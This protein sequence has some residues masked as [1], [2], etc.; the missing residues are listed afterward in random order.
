[1]S[2]SYLTVTALATAWI[3]RDEARNADRM[4]YLLRN[5]TQTAGRGN[6]SAAGVVLLCHTRAVAGPDVAAVRGDSSAEAD[7]FQQT[8]WAAADG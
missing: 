8:E 4:F 3:E 1:M 7:V 2:R 5:P 6:R